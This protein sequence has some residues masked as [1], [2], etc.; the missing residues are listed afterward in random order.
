MEDLI[1]TKNNGFIKGVAKIFVK[2][3]E[4]LKITDRP[5]HCSDKK[6]NLIYVKNENSW[7]EDLKYENIDKSI[8]NVAKK[9]I[10]IIKK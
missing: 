5:I 6:N 3:L 1:Y 4:E 8:D 7:K 10:Q 2:N 9:Q